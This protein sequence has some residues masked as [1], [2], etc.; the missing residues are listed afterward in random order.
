MIAYTRCCQQAAL[1]LGRLAAV[2][3]TTISLME[4]GL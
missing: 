4:Y 3:L 1:Q 2:P